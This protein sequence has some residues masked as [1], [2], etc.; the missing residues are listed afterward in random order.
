MTSEIGLTGAWKMLNHI[1]D[2]ISI[3]VI[4]GLKNI[5]NVD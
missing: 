3:K 5:L 1:Y 2:Q 4:M